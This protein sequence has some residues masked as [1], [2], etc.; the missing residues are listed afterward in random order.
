[1]E[2]AFAVCLFCAE[3]V[4]FIVNESEAEKKAISL[5][6]FLVICEIREDFAHYG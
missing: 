4:A 2:D 6:V 5:E 3:K 1:M